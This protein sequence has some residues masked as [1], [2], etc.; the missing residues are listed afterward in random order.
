MNGKRLSILLILILSLCLLL[1]SG[2][3]KKS[4]E[5]DNSIMFSNIIYHDSEELSPEEE[6]LISAASKMLATAVYDPDT[7]IITLE[8]TGTHSFNINLQVLCYDAEGYISD[9][10]TLSLD[11]LVPGDTLKIRMVANGSPSACQSAKIAAELEYGDHLLK[12]KLVPLKLADPSDKQAQLS[13][14]P[15]FA[16][17]CEFIIHDY[18][19]DYHYVMSKFECGMLSDNAFIRLR[20]NKIDGPEGGSE[21]ISYRILDENQVIMH[22]GSLSFF[23]LK[24]GETISLFID[25]L[26]L[27]P[28]SY[29]FQL[30]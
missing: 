13:I 27:E 8:N 17:P 29:I 26:D 4:D 2:C 14:V 3:G 24:A 19:G 20:L 18:Y 30:V 25:T 28:G 12:T 16:L 11:S 10:P 22:S 5:A 21:S 6:E 23:N 9:N 7:R 15:D 1:L